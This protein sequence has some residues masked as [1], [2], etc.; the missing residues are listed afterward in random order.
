[1]EHAWDTINQF[2]IYV[3]AIKY[4]Y[5]TVSIGTAGAELGNT[6]TPDQK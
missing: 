4:I 2:P 5:N 3:N 6:K 1:M